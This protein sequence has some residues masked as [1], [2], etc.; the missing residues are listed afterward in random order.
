LIVNNNFAGGT[1]L[2]TIPTGIA[3]A[4]LAEN[5]Y[6]WVQVGGVATCITNGSVASG[7]YVVNDTANDG[8]LDTMADG[9]EEQVLGYSPVA[10]VG[11]VGTIILKGLI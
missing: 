5:Y 3:I 2:G 4:A 9:E 11:T 8:D 6:G 10:D 7:E 1:G